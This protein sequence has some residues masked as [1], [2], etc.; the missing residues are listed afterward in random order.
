MLLAFWAIFIPWARLKVCFL[1]VKN[2]KKYSRHRPTCAARPTMFSSSLFLTVFSVSPLTENWC[3]YSPKDCVGIA[4]LTGDHSSITP[5]WHVPP[6]PSLSSF[7]HRLSLGQSFWCLY[8]IPRP[9]VL[10]SMRPLRSSRSYVSCH[11]YT[12]SSY[13]DIVPEIGNTIYLFDDWE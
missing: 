10:L 13:T 12:N 8:S 7:K 4:S 3:L 1:H 2:R 6:F 11:C 5:L 9:S